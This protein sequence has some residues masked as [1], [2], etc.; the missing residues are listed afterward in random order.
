MG[1]THGYANFV[2]L[3]AREADAAS[4]DDSDL[5]ENQ[6]KGKEI[7]KPIHDELRKQIEMFGADVE[8][9]PKKGF[10]KRSKKSSVCSDQTCNQNKDGSW[11]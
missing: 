7:L 5:I 11:N 8:F 4:H 6:Y 2:S 9:V 3:K 1:F 10:C